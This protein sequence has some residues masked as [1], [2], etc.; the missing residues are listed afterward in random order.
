MRKYLL[1]IPLIVLV[2]TGCRKDKLEAEDMMIPRLMIETRSVQ[3]G[4][5]GGNVVELPVSGTRIALQKEPLVSEFDI[6]NVEL[7]KVDMGLALLIQTTETGARAL[8]RGTVS[9]MGGRIVLTVNNNA[10]GARRVDSAIQNGNFY[11][12]VEVDDEEIGQ[13]VLDMK[14]TIKE[15]QEL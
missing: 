12:F 4:A 6:A 3:Y 9:N 7:V 10:I 14:K 2:F 1:L 15:L 8:Y 11:T 5:L 13:L